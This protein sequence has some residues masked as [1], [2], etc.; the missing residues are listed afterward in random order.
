MFKPALIVLALSSGTAFAAADLETTADG[1]ASTLVGAVGQY[2]FTVENIGN[3]NA[4]N[5][6]LTIDLPAT[7]TSPQ[8]YIMGDLAGYSGGCSLAGQQLTCPL[9]RLRRGTSAAVTVDIALPCSAASLDFIAT[10]DTTSNESNT[11]NNVDAHT[12]NLTYV[13]TA[14]PATVLVTNRHCTGT[15]LTA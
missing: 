7:H 10:A 13:A 12:A 3:R 11:A 4:D 1:P 15:G 8:V 14:I 9:G 6:T 5:V 2:T